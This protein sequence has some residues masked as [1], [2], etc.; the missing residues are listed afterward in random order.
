MCPILAMAGVGSQGATSLVGETWGKFDFKKEISITVCEESKCERNLEQGRSVGAVRKH[1]VERHV[2]LELDSEEGKNWKDE[3]QE[4]APAGRLKPAA[5][6]PAGR[7]GTGDA[8]EG[9]LAPRAR[10]PGTGVALV[11]AFA[12]TSVSSYGLVYL[13]TKK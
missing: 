3:G 4:G 13:F 6:V 7:A 9:A 2:G 10:R 5:A 11:W 12:L 8:V 1:F